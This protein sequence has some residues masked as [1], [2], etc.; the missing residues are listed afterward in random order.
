MCKALSSIEK[1][2]PLAAASLLFSLSSLPTTDLN[3]LHNMAEAH[4]DNIRMFC[5]RALKR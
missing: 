4:G 5:E 2:N 3:A 1:G